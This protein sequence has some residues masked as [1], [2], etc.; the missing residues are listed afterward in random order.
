MR[1]HWNRRGVILLGFL[2]L[3]SC[4]RS[5][6]PP[7][8]G[9]LSLSIVSGDL[10][11][12]PAGQ[13][14][15]NPLVV[16][17]TKPDGG[18]VK[19]Q[20]LN[21]RVVSGG[22]SVFA[23]VAIT[24]NAGIAQERWTLGADG[25]QRLEVR[26]VDTKTGAP[27]VF[28]TFTASIVCHDCWTSRAPLPSARFGF[29][30]AAINGKLY[31]AGGQVTVSATPPVL[32]SLQAYDPSTD[33]WADLAPM[34]TARTRTAATSLNGLLYVIGGLRPV[35]FDIEHLATVEAYDPARDTWMT[36]ASMPTARSGLAVAVVNGTLYAF[37]GRAADDGQ[38]EPRR[39]EAYDPA[40]NTWTTKA[41][42]LAGYSGS[43]AAVAG[44]FIYVVGGTGGTG[45]DTRNVQ[46]YDPA[47]DTWTFVTRLSTARGL[48]GAA[49]VNGLV[50]AIGGGGMSS[51]LNEVYD[52]STGTW[53]AKAP[54][55]TARS[56][57]GVAA[58]DGL[59]YTVGGLTDAARREVEVYRP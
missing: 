55:P 2:L 41:P 51:A 12:G 20:I 39:L 43:G 22:G 5:A 30:T 49:E 33:S 27:L 11:S 45:E 6:T 18:P 16:K 52:P 44:G 40:T 29:G 34:P 36:K 24:D 7:E 10:Q 56:L 54:L 19:D 4:D 32:S 21:F 25:P 9:E 35:Q 58:L 46:R 3:A 28:A 17:V 48:L 1:A 59:I 13:E 26:A 57:L 47:T 14:L 42:L 15:P 8:I 23:G 38:G 53:T 31:V 50:Y 37:G